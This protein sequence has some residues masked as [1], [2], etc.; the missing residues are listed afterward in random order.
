MADINIRDLL[1]I[2]EIPQSGY[3]KSSKQE[4]YQ[5][6]VYL[7]EEIGSPAK[8]RGLIDLLYMADESA[9]FNFFFNSPGGGL[10]ACMAIIEGIKE[11]PGTVRAIITGECHSAASMIALHCDDIIVT[12]SA[13][14][15]I[16]TANYGSSGNTHMVQNHVDFSSKLINKLLVQSYQ[17]FLNESELLDVS[18]GIEF[19]FD[20]EQIIKRLESRKA[21][22]VARLEALN[23]KVRP[24]RAKKTPV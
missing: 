12:D 17:G 5:H 21:F 19:W 4:M 1:E 14:M 20:A 9:E 7:D 24:S 11:C 6:M 18:K 10:S 16:H 2:E 22:M 15:M 8:Y 3:I 23:K 13:H